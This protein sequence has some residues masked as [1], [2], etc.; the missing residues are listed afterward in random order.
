MLGLVFEVEA[1]EAGRYPFCSD[2]SVRAGDG[3]GRSISSTIGA[4]ASGLR[5]P[6]GGDPGRGTCGSHWHTDEVNEGV[7]DCSQHR[8]FDDAQSGS[9]SSRARFGLGVSCDGTLP[10]Q[11]L[12]R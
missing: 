7:G 5:R 2:I 1:A 12:G 3:L 4:E 10:G 6:S 8:F 11:L 9:G